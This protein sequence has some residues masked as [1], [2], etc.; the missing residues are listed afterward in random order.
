MVGFPGESD[1]N[2]TGLMKFVKEQQFEHMGVFKY[3]QE[4]G[5]IA[6]GFEGQVPEKVKQERF[7]RLME[8][9]NGISKGI[10][11]KRVGKRIECIVEEKLDGCYFGRTVF[12]APE[13][14]GNIYINSKKPLRIGSIVRVVPQSSG[15]Y[16]LFGECK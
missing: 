15:D 11:Q 3:Y 13:V 7:R 1:E 9:Q 4:H 12:D 10:L 5:T 8:L 14:D 6:A 16:D 2:F